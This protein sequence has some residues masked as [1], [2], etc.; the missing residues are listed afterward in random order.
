MMN[1]TM[2][3][4]RAGLRALGICACAL[5]GA[6]LGSLPGA[7]PGAI[8][9]ARAGTAFDYVRLGGYLTNSG[10]LETFEHGSV[11]DP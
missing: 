2:R 1:N 3:R 7:I 6:L 11:I 5:L 10:A 9:A 4:P 8:P